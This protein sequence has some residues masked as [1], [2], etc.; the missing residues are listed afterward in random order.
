MSNTCF[1]K[2]HLSAW[3]QLCD[4]ADLT[5]VLD[6]QVDWM[7]EAYAKSLAATLA[8]HVVQGGRVIWRSA[9]ITPPYATIIVDAGF[10]VTFCQ[11]VLPLMSRA[12]CCSHCRIMHQMHQCLLAFCTCFRILGDVRTAGAASAAGRQRV[13]GPRQHVLLLLCCHAQ[14]SIAHPTD[15]ARPAAPG[16]LAHMLGHGCWHWC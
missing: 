1:G 15:A 10:K 4:D 3:L 13:H 12:H 8:Q 14:V 16:C 2:R 11:Q 5:M 9:A 6:C 7:D